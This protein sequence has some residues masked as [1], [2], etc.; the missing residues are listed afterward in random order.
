MHHTK[1]E[2]YLFIKKKKKKH[3]YAIKPSTTVTRKQTIHIC[4]PAV[5]GSL[6][7]FNSNH[8]VPAYKLKLKSW[9]QVCPLFSKE[10][11][12]VHTHRKKK[13]GSA[14][15]IYNKNSDPPSSFLSWNKCHARFTRRER[16]H[17]KCWD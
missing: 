14:T 3:N 9:I 7:R 2:F 4:I 5:T 8:R 1:K 13:Q 16:T 15:N 11:K 12:Q 17:I 10:K 6:Q